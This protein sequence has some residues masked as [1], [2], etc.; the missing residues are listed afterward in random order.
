M[1]F[2]RE[3]SNVMWLTALL[4]VFNTNDAYRM[5]IIIIIIIQDATSVSVEWKVCSTKLNR[6]AADI[7][8]S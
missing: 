1:H 6:L 8:V 2:F 4:L 7:K 3:E 5:S